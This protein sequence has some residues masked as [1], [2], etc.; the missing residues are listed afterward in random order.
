MRHR[1]TWKAHARGTHTLTSI[2]AFSLCALARSLAKVWMMLKN[3]G[4]SVWSR[5]PLRYARMV[6]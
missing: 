3:C 5:V 2:S 4:I 1:R 6:A